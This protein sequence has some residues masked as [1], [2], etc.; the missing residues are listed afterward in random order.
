MIDAFVTDISAR[1]N[2]FHNILSYQAVCLGPAPTQQG[3]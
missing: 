2:K 3:R 1:Q